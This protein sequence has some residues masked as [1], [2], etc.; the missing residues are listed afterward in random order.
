M[1]YE[2]FKDNILNFSISK[3]KK[4]KKKKKKA[5]YLK[6]NIKFQYPVIGKYLKIM[7]YGINTNG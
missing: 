1:I 2:I 6:R 7:K 4:K 3:K 5:F